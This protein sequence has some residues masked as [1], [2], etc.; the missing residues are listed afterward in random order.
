MDLR[1]KASANSTEIGTYTVLAQQHE[2][3]GKERDALLKQLAQTFGMK[4]NGR[5]SSNFL[6]GSFSLMAEVL[7]FI[8]NYF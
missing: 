3:M 6:L 4:S 2:K 7:S 8:S 1:K 5:T